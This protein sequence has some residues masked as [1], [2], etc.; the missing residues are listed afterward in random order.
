MHRLLP[1]GAKA[2]SWSPALSPSVVR[3]CAP[4]RRLIQRRQYRIDSVEVDGVAHLTRLLEESAGVMITPNHVCFPDPFLLAEAASRVGRPFYFMTAWQVF[5]TAP[6]I[7]REVLR[8]IG[9]FSVDREGNDARAFRTAVGI[10]KSEPNPLV[11]FPEGEMYHTNDLIMPFHEGG[12][13][14]LLTAASRSDRPV[15]CLPAA[16]RYEYT[17]DPT[18]ELLSLV[19]ELEARF[20]WRPGSNMTLVERIYRIAEAALALKEIEQLGETQTGTVPDRLRSL[21]QAL[22]ERLEKQAGL[23]GAEKITPVRVKQLR[24]YAIGQLEGL[25]DDSPEWLRLQEFLDD[26]FLATQLS[27][28]PGDYLTQ[29]P[30]VERTAET[31]DKLEEDILGVAHARV[32]GRRKALLRFGE[33]IPIPARRTAQPTAAELTQQMESTVQAE[34]TRLAQSAPA[35]SATNGDT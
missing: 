9:C 13:R 19:D 1:I 6:W 23:N 12:A 10:L 28:Y 22:L 27:S 16:L 2:G 15:A 24:Q 7:Q 34:L 35:T 8:R 32:R 21:C 14:I 4:L 29:N 20:F 33:P 3:L 30:D 25:S 5:G 11:V 18:S 26:V 31:L 17:V